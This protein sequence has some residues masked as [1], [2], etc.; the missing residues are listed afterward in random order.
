M[1]EKPIIEIEHLYVMRGRQLALE[2]I[3]LIVNRLDFLGIIGPNGGGKTTLLKTIIGL[4]KPDRGKLLITGL[5]PAKAR[6]K[7]GY[8]PQF[9]VFDKQYPIDVWDVVLMGRLGKAG[10]F[11][12]YSRRDKNDAEWALD[13]VDMSPFRNRPIGELSGGQLQRVIIARAL[14][15]RPEVLLLDEPTASIDTQTAASFYNL[16]NELNKELTIIIVS[17]DIGAISSYV[18]SLA[19]LNRK[20]F[21]HGSEELSP[22]I[23][24]AT[25]GCPVDLI[26]HGVPHRV[27]KQHN[28]QDD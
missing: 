14:V 18:R 27:L 3:N 19:C 6:Y 4:I 12:R 22:E 2:D 26:A 21:Y 11:R 8:V 25:Y 24:E 28:H 7:C 5:P 17:H 15:S 16:L 23:V 10:L 1:P 9:T 20:L 13:M